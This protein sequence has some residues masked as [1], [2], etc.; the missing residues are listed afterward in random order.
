M[1]T[2]KERMALKRKA[3]STDKVEAHRA[4]MAQDIG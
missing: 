4:R 2:N 1:V 3:R